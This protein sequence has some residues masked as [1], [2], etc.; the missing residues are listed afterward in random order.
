MD[1]DF[2]IRLRA[3]AVS[4]RNHL[5]AK[6]AM[7]EN[8]A[9][10]HEKYG[11]ILVRQRLIAGKQIYDTQPPEAQRKA[12]PDEM[13]AIVRTTMRKRLRHRLYDVR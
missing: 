6:L 3:K 9:V 11:S 8:L 12:V 7:I 5:R 13:T 1:Q 10:A 4:L 2:D